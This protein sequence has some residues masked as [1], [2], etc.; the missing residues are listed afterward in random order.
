MKLSSSLTPRAKVS[1]SDGSDAIFIVSG[2]VV[3]H[4]RAIGSSCCQL[5]IGLRPPPLKL[6]WQLYSD[7]QENT[8]L[9]YSEYPMPG[10]PVVPMDEVSLII[11][12]R[13]RGT[14]P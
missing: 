8:A 5:K 6:V 4:V 2:I 1:W 11:I 3:S 13:V 7:C 9:G 10:L 14:L 12:T